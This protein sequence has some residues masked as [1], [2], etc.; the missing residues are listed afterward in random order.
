MSSVTGRIKEIKQPRGGFIRPSEFEAIRLSDENILNEAENVHG[1]VIGMV[2]DYLTRFNMG[3]DVNEAFKI[4]ENAN[5]L[6]KLRDGKYQV[7][8]DS[9]FKGGMNK[10]MRVMLDYNKVSSNDEGGEI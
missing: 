3:T 9:V 6:K 8:P 7:N 5:F 4:L 10:R 2:V 1:S